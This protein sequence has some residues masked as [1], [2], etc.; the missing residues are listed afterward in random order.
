MIIITSLF[1]FIDYPYSQFIV[2]Q[3]FEESRHRTRFHKTG[4]SVYT[5]DLGPN[6]AIDKLKLL[7]GL[8]RH[9]IWF[10]T[11]DLDGDQI[12][13]IGYDDLEV[14]FRN[15]NCYGCYFNNGQHYA[16]TA[17]I[18]DQAKIPLRKLKLFGISGHHKYFDI[19]NVGFYCHEEPL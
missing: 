8:C 18:W 3:N 2:P 7:P 6:E 10:E 5:F 1:I 17:W 9:R 14:D 4:D 12:R 15:L 16:R 19:I 11:K 13:A